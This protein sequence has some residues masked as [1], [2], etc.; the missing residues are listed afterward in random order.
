MSKK[1]KK[2]L[3]CYD[4]AEICNSTASQMRTLMFAPVVKYKQNPAFKEF[5][6]NNMI[7]KFQ[8]GE[9]S[10]QV[11]NRFLTQLHR[12]VLDLMLKKAKL[13][14]VKEGYVLVSEFSEYEMLEELG[15][16]YKN[17][18]V[19]FR[20]II[21][22]FQ[23]IN[24]IW[25]NNKREV[26]FHILRG[27][28]INKLTGQHAVIFDDSY[29]NYF[30]S[31]DIGVNY[32]HLINDIVA[33]DS[34]ILKAI[35]RFVISNSFE[36]FK[37]SLINIL[38]KIGIKRENGERQYQKIIKT[39]KDNKDLLKEK[40]NIVLTDGDIVEYEYNQ[41]ISF[42]NKN[43]EQAESVLPILIKNTEEKENL[44]LKLKELVEKFNNFSS[45]M[46]VSYEPG[47]EITIETETKKLLIEIL[48]EI[49]QISHGEKSLNINESFDEKNRNYL[50]KIK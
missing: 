36:K 33:L 24:I 32:K 37:M 25:K 44:K 38:E 35:V 29:I 10:L 12:D 41:N 39:V 28:R 45:S 4:K 21:R 13:K 14:A 26:S 42:Y 19:W 3:T 34:P 46:I 20:N 11:R 6:K 18:T 49:L 17:N 47:G 30:Y 22:E 15:H 1:S 8:N 50:L 40:F 48:N 31:R 2:E 27:Y 5:I 23:D 7:L 43:Q 16:K 9:D